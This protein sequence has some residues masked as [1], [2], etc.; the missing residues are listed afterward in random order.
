[1]F[2]DLVKALLIYEKEDK[3]KDTT[4]KSK[5]TP[6]DKDDKD[7]KIDLKIGDDSKCDKESARF[8]SMQIF[9]VS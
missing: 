6:K 9:N 7:T 8:P 2:V 4:K 5:E 1:M 3:E